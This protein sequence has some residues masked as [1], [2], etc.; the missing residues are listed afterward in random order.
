MSSPFDTATGTKKEGSSISCSP[1]A[2]EIETAIA[3]WSRRLEWIR[4]VSRSTPL[5]IEHDLCTWLYE[6]EVLPCQDETSRRIALAMFQDREC[7]NHLPSMV[8]WPGTLEYPRSTVA[9]MESES[10]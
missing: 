7:G 5:A 4:Q 6:A 3:H 8:S 1:I 10:A 2:L 9:R